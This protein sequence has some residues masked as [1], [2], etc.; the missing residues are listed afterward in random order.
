MRIL[1]SDDWGQTFKYTLAEEVENNGNCE[2]T[3]PNINI[4]EIE[5][6]SAKLKVN[7]G[8]IKVEVIDRLAFDITE[9]AP[10]ARGGFI[11]EEDPSLAT[12]ITDLKSSDILI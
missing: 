8:I 3:L 2:V 9:K 1:L 11:V 6:G 10:S 12:E 5:V 7:A 4:G